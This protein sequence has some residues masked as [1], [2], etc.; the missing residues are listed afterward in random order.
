MINSMSMS[1]QSLNQ[2]QS[3][4]NTSESNATK[5]TDTQEYKAVSMQQLRGAHL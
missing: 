3:T 2:Y 1:Y 4:F 5:N